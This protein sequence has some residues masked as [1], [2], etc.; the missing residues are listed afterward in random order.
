MLLE[1][2]VE[3]FKNFQKELIFKLDEI[4][5]YEFS[6][7]AVKDDVVKTALVY[8]MNGSG[9]TNLALAIFDICLNLTDN[10][11]NYDH[12]NQYINLN[13]DSNAIFYYKF[14]LGSSTLEYKYEKDTPQH[15]VREEL[16]I[17]DTKIIYYDHISHEGSV[18]LEGTETLNTDLNEKNIS[19]VKYISSNSVLPSNTANNTFTKF[20][21]FVNR[22]LL[23]SSLEKNFYQGFMLGNEKLSSAIIE[24]GRLKDFEIFLK[25]AGIEYNL[26][27]KTVGEKKLI[28]C[29]FDKKQA[30]FFNV[31][32]RGTCSLTLFYYWLAKLDDVSLVFIDEFDAFYHNNLAREVVQ[33]VLKS[34]AQAIITTHNTSI[35]DNDLLRPD[36]YFNLFDGNIKSF[37]NLT[38]KELRKAHNVEKMYRAG[39]FDE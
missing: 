19:F 24:S 37:A 1:F 31:A 25:N 13:V 12:Y 26:V 29:K 11:K 22:M 21:D 6:V 10:E 38:K 36:C 23:F 20:I 28:F 9:K 14:K 7:D 8:G 15:I 4:K 18:T 30:N 16:W 2:R 35:M 33:K 39:S 3:R 5:N 27:A 34:K 17:D 32:S